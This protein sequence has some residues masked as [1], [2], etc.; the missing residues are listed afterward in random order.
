MN[1]RLTDE[2]MM[3]Q[4]TIRKFVENE[5]I[6]LKMMCFEMNEKENQG[7]LPKKWKSCS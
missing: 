6:P 5:L 4:K 1:L 7:F 2:Q 3:V